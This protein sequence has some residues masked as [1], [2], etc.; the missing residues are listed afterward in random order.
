MPDQDVSTTAAAAARLARVVRQRRGRLGL[1]LDALS[2]RTGLS[3]GFLSEMEAGEA[4]PTLNTL[5]RLAEALRTS[6][7][8]LLGDITYPEASATDGPSGTDD[9]PAE[10]PVAEADIDHHRDLGRPE[11]PASGA[12]HADATLGTITAGAV[13]TTRRPARPLGSWLAGA[14]RTY[15]LT[16]PGASDYEVLLV[17]GTPT[18]HAEIVGHEGEEFCLVLAGAI[19]AEVDGV[20][21]RLAEGDALHYDS[22]LPHRLT[23]TTP[24]SRLLLIL[25]PMS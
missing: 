22:G 9:E 16:A 21:Y 19:N 15:L 13:R 14:G 3:K 25:T 5:V 4:N 8:G 24:R 20:G 1:T 17:D 11:A 6:P 12:D 18:H 23:P 7:A 2:R 10:A